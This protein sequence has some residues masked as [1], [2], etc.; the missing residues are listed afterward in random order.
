MPTA[1]IEAAFM[2]HPGD[3]RRIYDAAQRRRL[4]EAVV[5]GVRAYKK[6]VDR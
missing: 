1:Y 2:T 6:L 4:A 5:E 3:A